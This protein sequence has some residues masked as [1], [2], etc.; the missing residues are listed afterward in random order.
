MI[1]GDLVDIGQLFELVLEDGAPSIGAGEQDSSSRRMLA[2]RCRERLGAKRVGNEI[3]V[4]M[5][6]GQGLRGRRTDRGELQV[7]QR[8]QVATSCG[9]PRR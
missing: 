9:E 3:R 8:P 6:D 4:Q 2:Q 5:K 1:D 7:S